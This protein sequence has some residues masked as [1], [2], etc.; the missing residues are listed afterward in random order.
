[1]NKESP[2][3]SSNNRVVRGVK[4]A[5]KTIKVAGK[6]MFKALSAIWHIISGIVHGLY[7]LTGSVVGTIVG[8]S[9]II[10]TYGIAVV[11]LANLL[12]FVVNPT[13]GTA[14][15][16]VKAGANLSEYEKAVLMAA[17]LDRDKIAKDY[18][19][20]GTYK[21]IFKD[22]KIYFDSSSIES[23]EYPAKDIDLFL[24][25]DEIYNRPEI[26]AENETFKVMPEFLYGSWGSESGYAQGK[27]NRLTNS[28][29]YFR[30][31]SSGYADPLGV[32]PKEWAE[33]SV[34]GSTSVGCTYICAQENKEMPDEQRA[35][36]GGGNALFN[37]KDAQY[38][39]SDNFDRHSDATKV[40][41]ADDS[42]KYLNSIRLKGSSNYA[43][44]QRRGFN[45]WLPDAFYNFAYVARIIYQG[46]DRST[47]YT[48][49]FYNTSNTVAFSEMCEDI[50]VTDEE[51][52]I[53]YGIY[54]TNDRFTHE[55]VSCA[56]NNEAA[57]GEMKG[58]LCAFETI[59]V[60]EGYLE[61]IADKY[62]DVDAA[63]IDN[64]T[65]AKELFGNCT[66]NNITMTNDCYLRKIL[67]AIDSK[68]LQNEY[69]DYIL[70]ACK[71]MP[72]LMSNP[73]AYTY[74]SPSEGV[75]RMTYGIMDY[76]KGARAVDK[77][78]KLVN[79]Y[80]NYQDSSGDYRYRLYDVD[81]GE[82]SANG[83]T[84]DTANQVLVAT[85]KIMNAYYADYKSDKWKKDTSS[86]DKSK[87]GYY[88]KTLNMTCTIDGKR[89][90]ARRDTSG[91]V[92]GVLNLLGDCTGSGS[93][94]TLAKGKTYSSKITGWKT[95]NI[96]KE[97]VKALK[98]GDIIVSD[99]YAG[100]YG[101]KKDGKYYCYR[102][103]WTDDIIDSGKLK[104]EPTVMTDT[105]DYSVYLRRT[106]CAN[107]D[108]TDTV[109]TPGPSG[110]NG[111]GP[112][113]INYFKSDGSVDE[114]AIIA[115]QHLFSDLVDISNIGK[116][117]LQV[118][119]FISYKG[120]TY[121]LNGGTYP[122]FWGSSYNYNVSI[123]LWGQC[124]WWSEGRGMLYW[125]EHYTSGSD[126][127]KRAGQLGS[128][129][130]ILQ[131]GSTD[132]G[133]RI[134][135]AYGGGNGWSSVKPI[136]KGGKTI[137]TDSIVSSTAYSVTGHT[138]Y[139]EA[140]DAKNKV[141]YQSHAN[142]TSVCSRNGYLNAPTWSYT[143]TTVYVNT[144]GQ[145]L[146]YNGIFKSTEAFGNYK[147]Y[148]SAA[149]DYYAYMG[150]KL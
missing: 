28:E 135:H 127:K 36:L 74:A 118:P 44:G 149:V 85:H 114:D 70:N 22:Y 111:K 10:C 17:A 27:G 57:T 2:P 88:S 98:P 96:P 107:R 112:F 8:L 84:V 49:G 32:S 26:N 46:K 71:K 134:A 43:Y 94:T 89:I 141:C 113:G 87:K 48:A 21:D 100:V 150:E 4:K 6:V 82:D 148:N 110:G 30:I 12:V 138:W 9:L 78:I 119:N 42:Y 29:I 139:I 68:S 33:G 69:P 116:Q 129:R 92:Y 122:N 60:H 115:M 35:I 95:G 126:W 144:N 101:G 23:Y 103:R 63:S 117:S 136:T 75:V 140:Y 61:E 3:Q 13:S 66:S 125:Y 16:G 128:Y 54:A 130:A 41:S 55:S 24:L 99:E 53:M 50:G 58:V 80:Y 56:P 120:K 145:G 11:L 91:F 25:L 15:D 18:D 65:I 121:K 106:E 14:Q 40:K 142:V 90:T 20:D 39:T 52:S 131:A 133:Y 105:K 64:Y 67:D 34:G 132:Y 104:C 37:T 7:V 45:T 77:G 51:R 76:V 83:E 38:I 59:L 5:G 72:N 73:S 147:P 81:F 109:Y 1:M 146:G 31:N 79:F 19:S 47:H 123:G 137:K 124:T 62:K 86:A 93:L 97:G 143:G 108:S 102:F